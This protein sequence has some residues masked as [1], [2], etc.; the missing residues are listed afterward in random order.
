[1]SNLTLDDM[2]PRIMFRQRASVMRSVPRLLQGPFRNALKLALAQATWEN[3]LQDEVRQERG[4]KL[5]ELLPRMLL[6]RSPGGG[7]TFLRGTRGVA[8]AS[9][10]LA[11]RRMR[12]RRG[13]DVEQRATRAETLIQLGEFSSVRRALEGS[14]LAPG[15]TATMNALTDE[16]R[17]PALQRGPL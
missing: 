1:M 11:R 12:R 16:R 5:L 2:D 10:S 3:H 9:E 4:W 14:E 13:D 8:A 7:L 17:R 15:T 6:H